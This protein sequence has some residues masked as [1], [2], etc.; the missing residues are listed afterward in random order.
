M[1][2]KGD[3][4]LENHEAEDHYDGM[5]PCDGVYDARND[6]KRPCWPVY[7]RL[8]HSCDGWVIGG[9]EQV[10]AMIEDLQEILDKIAPRHS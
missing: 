4:I 10:A 2:R 6:D 5:E 1:Y 7:A 8:P 3:A 9:A